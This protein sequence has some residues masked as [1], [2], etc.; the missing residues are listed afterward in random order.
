[1]FRLQE[2]VMRESRLQ[3]LQ[4]ATRKEETEQVQ[5][6][7]SEL[8]TK[9]KIQHRTRTVQANVFQRPATLKWP[10]PP[11]INRTVFLSISQLEQTYQLIPRDVLDPAILI[12]DT[13]RKWYVSIL[14][15]G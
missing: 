14:L 10:H 4:Q 7:T 3:R 13:E 1:M 6:I 15:L 9:L 12:F 2:E 11:S 5:A 8:G